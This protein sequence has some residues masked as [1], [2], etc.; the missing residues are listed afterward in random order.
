MI[1]LRRFIAKVKRRETPLYASLYDYGKAIRQFSVPTIQPLH[2]FLYNEWDIRTSV[3]HNFW[4]VVYYEPIFKSQCRKVGKGFTMGYCGNGTTR[5]CGDLQIFLGANVT[6]QDN[7]MLSGLK[8][9]D[10]PELHVGDN[11]YIGPCVNISVGKKIAIGNHCL[12]GCRLLA[13][14]TGHPLQDVIARMGGGG[15]GAEPES[16]RPVTIGDF[17]LV[18]LD[19]VVY[20]GVTMGDGAVA[21]IGTHV[22]RDV[23]PFCLVSGNPMKIRVKLPIPPEIASIVGE[24]RYQEYLECHEKVKIRR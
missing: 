2:N 9:F 15:G 24:Q 7:T 21:I 16:I 8:V 18:G 19:T 11:S 14:N 10:K 4:R 12:L 6:I 5:I 20:P 22:T 13:D 1:S 23:P 17:C 3:W